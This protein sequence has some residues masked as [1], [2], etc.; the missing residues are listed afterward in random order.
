MIRWC[1]SQCFEF[2]VP[3]SAIFIPLQFPTSLPGLRSDLARA[4]ELLRLT[5]KAN[6]V[7]KPSNVATKPEK[8][9]T[10]ESQNRV[11]QN[12]SMIIDNDIIENWFYFE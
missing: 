4:Q 8:F 2:D 7:L 1:R 5:G 3:A 12:E 11:K 6:E 10:K 9:Q